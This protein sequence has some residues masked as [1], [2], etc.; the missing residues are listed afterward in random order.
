M[1][2]RWFCMFQLQINS[3]KKLFRG[4]KCGKT[5]EVTMSILDMTPNLVIYKSINLFTSLSIY[6]SIYLSLHL[7]VYLF[8]SL[9]IYHF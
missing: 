9:S 5:A 6:L 7:I 3:K 8:K 4:K 2:L 1:L